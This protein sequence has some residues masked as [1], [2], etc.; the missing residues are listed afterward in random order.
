MGLFRPLAGQL[1]FA[2]LHE[3]ENLQ[4]AMVL[5]TTGNNGKRVSS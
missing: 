4:T 5:Q 3:V 1:D 2:L